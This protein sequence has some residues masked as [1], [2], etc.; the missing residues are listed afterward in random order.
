MLTQCF[1]ILQDVLT[2]KLMRLAASADN[3]DESKRAVV[4]EAFYWLRLYLTHDLQ[5]DPVQW[6][7][8]DLL[9]QHPEFA[10]TCDDLEA[11]PSTLLAKLVRWLAPD[12]CGRPPSGLTEED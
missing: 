11:L 9:C 3:S 8:E 7:C 12:P 6:R 1:G 2:E 4:D 10:A 5:S